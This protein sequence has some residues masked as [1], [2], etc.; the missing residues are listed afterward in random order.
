MHLGNKKNAQTMKA[1]NV[2]GEMCGFTVSW[3][4]HHTGCGVSMYVFRESKHQECIKILATDCQNY[5][6]EL[7]T[8]LLHLLTPTPQRHPPI[9]K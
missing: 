9:H 4:C 6:H 8:H 7:C 2:T 1:E 5:T 3:I